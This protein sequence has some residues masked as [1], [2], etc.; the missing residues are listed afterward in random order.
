MPMFCSELLRIDTEAIIRAVMVSLCS[1]RVL[2][3][4]P[5][6]KLSSSF[7]T[8]SLRSRHRRLLSCSP[9]IMG[10]HLVPQC[11]ATALQTCFC[12]S[13]AFVWHARRVALRFS[14][15]VRVWACGKQVYCVFTRRSDEIL[16]TMY[17]TTPSSNCCVCRIHYLEMCL[18]C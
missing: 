8:R 13:N 17:W 11:G 1:S 2:T 10:Y 6:V 15:Y 18:E 7:R 5:F 4:I 12:V 3:V 9:A 14:W 16:C